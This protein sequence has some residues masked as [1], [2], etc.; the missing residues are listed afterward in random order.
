M[1]F[2]IRDL[3]RLNVMRMQVTLRTCF[4]KSTFLILIFVVINIISAIYLLITR[5]ITRQLGSHI[6]IVYGDD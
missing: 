5:C 6:F 2:I 3:Y 4:T 1:K